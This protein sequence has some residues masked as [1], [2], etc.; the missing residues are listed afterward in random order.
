MLRLISNKPMKKRI[1]LFFILLLLFSP[2]CA[3]GETFPVTDALG[4][5]I[6]LESRPQRVVSFLGSFGETWLLS[7]G[8]L[9]G[10]TEDAVSERG[11]E[12]GENVAIIGT[13]KKPNLELTAALNPGLI[14]LS[15]DLEAHMALRPVLDAMGTPYLFFSVNTWQE[16]MDMAEICCRLNGRMD[17]YAAQQEKIQAPIEEMIKIAQESPLYGQHTVLLLRAYSS[18]VKAKGSDNLCGAI[19]KDMG[20]INIADSE[21]TLLEN[22]SMEAILALNPD[23][24]MVTTMGGDPEASIR[25]LDTKFASGPVW[26]ALSAVKNSQVFYLDRTLFH[27]KPNSRW[28]ESYQIIGDIL[29][30]P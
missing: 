11:L 14:L 16:Y 18:G 9:A 10:V 28:A 21:E 19:L 20:L 25:A 3:R 22:L 29:Y 6:I 7:G 30:A 15:A 26:Q 8:S 27:L 1:Y 5:E 13:N 24:I 2:A 17:L 23:Y 12:L 4:R